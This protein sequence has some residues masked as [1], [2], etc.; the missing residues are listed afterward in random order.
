MCAMKQCQGK[1]GDAELGGSVSI[2]SQEGHTGRE[3]LEL[4]EVKEG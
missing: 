2:G 3:T 4:N 1:T